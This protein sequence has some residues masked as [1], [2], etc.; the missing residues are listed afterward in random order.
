MVQRG[1]AIRSCENIALRY[2]CLSNFVPTSET[3]LKLYMHALVHIADEIAVE[4]ALLTRGWQGTG[5]ALPMC[6]PIFHGSVSV[7]DV[8]GVVDEESSMYFE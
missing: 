7:H 5:T 8:A 3:K 6:P 2:S 4:N 1:L